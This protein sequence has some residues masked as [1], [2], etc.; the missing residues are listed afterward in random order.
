MWSL[1]KNTRIDEKSTALRETHILFF[2]LRVFSGRYF[3]L[4]GL[5]TEIY[6][7]NLPTEIYSVNLPIQSEYRRTRIN[8][9][10]GHF[11]PS[12]YSSLKAD[13]TFLFSCITFMRFYQVS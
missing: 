10:F 4:F 11:S 3:P 1:R 8:S 13:L 7:V 2:Y 12:A 5:N 6:S 9:V